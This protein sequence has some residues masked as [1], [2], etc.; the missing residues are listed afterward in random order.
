MQFIR[1]SIF[2]RISCL[3]MAIS[4]LIQSCS[5][6]ETAQPN[7]SSCHGQPI[8]FPM[9]APIADYFEHTL[10]LSWS[11]ENY[12]QYDNFAS[13]YLEL[14]GDNPQAQVHIQLIEEE[15]ASY[16]ALGFEGYVDAKLGQGKISP[17]QKEKL[18][19][20]KTELEGFLSSQEPTLSE[21]TTFLN[22]QKSQLAQSTLCE[23]EKELMQFYLELAQGYGQFF[24]KHYQVSEAGAQLRGC[25]FW[26]ALGC[27]IW[28][29]LV[30][31]VVS[32][33]SALLFAAQLIDIV[34]DLFFL[35][36]QEAEIVVNLSLLAL[37]IKSGIDV[38]KRCCDDEPVESQDCFTPTGAVIK[39]VDCDSIEY[40]IFGASR[41]SNTIWGNR[42]TSPDSAMT[43]I[44]TLRFAVPDPSAGSFMRA[45]IACVAD[46]RTVEIFNFNRLESF[47]FDAGPIRLQWETPPPAALA[48]D[49]LSRG[50]FT[51]SVNSPRDTRH[52]EYEWSITP[53][54]LIDSRAGNNTAVIQF[55]GSGT[56]ETTVTLT[57]ICTGET[58]T[59]SA[60]TQIE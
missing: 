24:Y 19:T 60:T 34:S 43:E 6:T 35:T 28:A 1:Q 50:A 39:Q 25:N 8:P 9:T 29:T 14:Y 54:H 47:E 46:E 22:G 13:Y 38:Y 49:I 20:F 51:V 37:G 31:A 16:E 55:L 48:D 30:G 5:T 53:P 27:G 42:N 36:D 17:Q 12:H 26:R 10:D 18:L 41:Y 52:L 33:G 2:F 45:T 4:I 23:K 58:A 15:A 40:T 57:N 7:N 3:L 32:G 56:A 59:L 21:Y 44:P 11:L